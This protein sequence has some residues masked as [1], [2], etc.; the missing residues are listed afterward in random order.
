VEGED[1]L[2]HLAA[3]RIGIEPA[4]VGLDVLPAVLESQRGIAPERVRADAC[5]GA[6]AMQ[7]IGNGVGELVRV[8]TGWPVDRDAG[9]AA[10]YARGEL[11][12]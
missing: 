9:D 10:R 5:N 7:R 12:R 2:E 4:Q 8:R 6:G 1:G 11:G 3:E